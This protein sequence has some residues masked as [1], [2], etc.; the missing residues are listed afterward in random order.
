[1]KKVVHFGAGALGKGLVIPV[2]HDSEIEVIVVD[3]DKEV[4]NYLNERQAYTM[5]VPGEEACPMREIPVDHA[6]LLGVEDTDIVDVI[7]SVDT[8]TTSVRR[9]NLAAVARMVTEAWGDTK[10][11][12]KVICCENIENVSNLF[13][14]LLV[15]ANEK[16]L[17]LGHIIVPDTIVDRGCAPDPSDR[18]AVY[19][20]PFFEIS[21]DANVLANSGI[22]LIASVE[23]IEKDFMR[24]RFLLNTHVD[25]TSYFGIERGLTG[26]GAAV[27]DEELQNYLAP[28]MEIIKAALQSTYN[29]SEEEYQKW[30]DF[31][32][33][34]WASSD[35]SRPLSSI[36]RSIWAKLD[37]TERIVYPLVLAAEHGYNIDA[38]LVLVADVVKAEINNERI[39]QIEAEERCKKLWCVSS[40]GESIYQGVFTLI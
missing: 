33:N 1:M 8:V 3:A 27:R 4:V 26:F 11:D 10:E 23:N 40:I 22:K 36:A 16:N 39:T 37:Y 13:N 5:H 18:M 30:V 17:N 21:V 20:E 34:R 15:E 29:M 25:L 9:E 24:K 6:Y 19:T 32:H 28:Y 12:K 7:A 38:G 31:Y 14:K 2:L 35:N